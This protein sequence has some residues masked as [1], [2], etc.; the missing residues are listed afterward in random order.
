MAKF[1]YIDNSNVYIEGQ[2][3]AA[4]Q[5]G[6]AI[7]IKDATRRKTLNR[8]YRIDFGKLYNFVTKNGDAAVSRAVVFGS[9]PPPNDSMWAIAKS[10]GFEL[11]IE[12]RNAA[13]KEKGVDTGIAV[14][15]CV[16]ALMHADKQSDKILLVAGDADFVPAVRRLTGF[17]F[18]VDVAFWSHASGKLKRIC[19]NFID[20]NP[21]FN[22]LALNAPRKSITARLT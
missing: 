11:V 10:A 6:E 5:S 8:G 3:V 1:I 19:S 20:L 14:E 17:G 21:H 15:M 13:N 9:R 12:D 4:V 18:T 7:N 16:D 22:E 2:R